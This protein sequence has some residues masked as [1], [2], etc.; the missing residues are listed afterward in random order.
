MSAPAPLTALLDPRA[1]AVVGASDKPNKLGQAMM[2]SLRGYGGAVVGINPAGSRDMFPDLDAARRVHP[3]LDLAVLCVPAPAVPDA[4]RQC[5]ASGVAAA[6]VCAGG[7]AEIGAAGQAVHDDLVAAVAETGVRL[8]GPNT[9]GFFRPGARLFASF[10]PGVGE[11]GSGSVGIVAAS[12]GVNH[13]LAFQLD[14]I[15]AGVSTGVGLGAA[16]DVTAVDVLHHLADDPQTRAVALHLESVPDG[17]GLLAAVRRVVEVKPLVAL[18]VGKNDIS[19]FAQS[20][21]GS[22]AT[23]W[24]T[25]RALLREAGAVV[26]DSEI[27][28]VNAA[29]ALTAVRAAPRPRAGVGL[30]TGQAGPGLIIADELSTRGVD[31]PRVAPATK[32]RLTELLPPLTFLDNPVDTGRPGPTFADVL[33]TVGGDEGVDVLGVYSIVEPVASLPDALATAALTIPVVVAVDG[34]GR[35]V[36][37]VRA[38]A[39]GQVPV[40]VGPTALAQGLHAITADA[41]ARSMRTPAPAQAAGPRLHDAAAWAG[42]AWSEARAKDLLDA[43]GVRTPRRAVCADLAEARAAFEK[44]GPSVAV[45]VL[46]PAV[47]HKSD[48]GGVHLGVASEAD[49][50]RAIAALERIGAPAFLV[51]EMAPGGVDLLLGARIDP[52]F[53]P[54]AV[55]G[56]GGVATELWDDTAICSLPAPPPVVRALPGQLRSEPLVDGYRGGPVLDRDELVRVVDA[57]T[58]ALLSDAGIQE[59][60]INPLRVGTDGL[61]ALDAVVVAVPAEERA[62]EKVE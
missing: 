50:D 9:S 16:I 22:L 39:A 43:L 30:V 5:G 1:I 18:V 48:I 8:L 32:E 57:L 27:E 55:L 45:K 56:V 28:L 47:L 24:S 34:H 60:E 46:D 40:L 29:S 53:G 26:V 38:A 41:H 59:I 52:V 49:L 14:R 61:V 31:V 17:P 23:A 3:A 62:E 44:L 10:V 4:L 51:E 33:A 6:V 21:T 12:G 36:E 15:G 54:I 2:Q 13:A 58:E 19:E 35:A 7:F 25:T 37:D 20:H 11:L 42:S